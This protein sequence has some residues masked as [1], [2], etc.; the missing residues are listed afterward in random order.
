VTG[1]AL[2]TVALDE[3]AARE[4]IAATASQTGLPCTDPL[5]F[6]VGGLVDALL[7]HGG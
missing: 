4:I 6:G 2:N 1:I 3:D 7:A 5:R